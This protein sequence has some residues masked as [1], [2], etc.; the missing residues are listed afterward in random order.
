MFRSPTVCGCIIHMPS[1]RHWLAMVPPL[2]GEAH[3]VALLCDSLHPWPFRLSLDDVQELFALMGVRQAV[4]GGLALP[5]LEREQMAGGWSA[6]IVDR[7]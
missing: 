4:I 5:L 7:V 2:A 6:Y 1:P 3:G